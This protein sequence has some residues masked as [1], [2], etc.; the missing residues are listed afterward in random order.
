MAQIA[1]NEPSINDL[2]S[3]FGGAGIPAVEA[4][5]RSEAGA[6]STRIN[7]QQ[8]L[9]NLFQEEQLFPSKMREAEDISATRRAQLPGITAEGRLKTI[10]AETAESIPPSL[11][12]IGARK[13]AEAK[14]SGNQLKLVHDQFAQMALSDDLNERKIGIEGLKHTSPMIQ[15]ELKQ[16]AQQT[17]RL[18]EI[19]AQGEERRK[20]ID[21]YQKAGKYAPK[22]AGAKDPFTEMLSKGKLAEAYLYKAMSATDPAEKADWEA[23]AIAAEVQ[24]KSFEEA[25]AEAAAARAGIINVPQVAGQPRTTV[26]QTPRP[27]LPIVPRGAP[28]GPGTIPPQGPVVT[29]PLVQARPPVPGTAPPAIPPAALAKLKEGIPTP[30]KNG[31]VWM[32]KN[33]QPIRIP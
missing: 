25:K 14:L 28:I 6:E 13:E 33:G 3:L 5:R 21:A 18:A 9:Q 7:Q 8:A 17:R 31:Q 24:R 27:P 23:A 30:F 29:P 32:L 19:R 1:T 11:R 26:P 10:E 20:D 4:L 22:G 2:V 15:E 16:S 12:Q